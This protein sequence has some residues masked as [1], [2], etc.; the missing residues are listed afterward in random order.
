MKKLVT[1]FTLA[2]AILVSVC[3]LIISSQNAQLVSLNYILA[4]QNLVLSQ[5]LSLFFFIGFVA[6]S[7]GWWILLTKANF[8]LFQNKRKLTKLQNENE[9]LRIQLKDH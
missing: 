9:Q 6:A 3:V 5:V 2:A 1:F 8:K 7:V 4:K